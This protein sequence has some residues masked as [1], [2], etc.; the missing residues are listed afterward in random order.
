LGQLSIP[1]PFVRYLLH[2]GDHLVDLKGDIFQCSCHGRHSDNHSLFVGEG[3]LSFV[4][5]TSIKFFEI[6][7]EREVNGHNCLLCALLPLGYV[8]QN[9]PL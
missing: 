4:R 9:R 1:L 5:H 6:V 3:G 7:I 2:R 8:P